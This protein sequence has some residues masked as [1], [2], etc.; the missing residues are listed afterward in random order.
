MRISLK[1][2]V[3]WVLA[4]GLAY[5]YVIASGLPK[6]QSASGYVTRFEEFGYSMSFM[7]LVGIYETA[8]GLLLLIPMT[9]FYAAVALVVE[10]AGATYSHLATGVGS[11]Y[12][13]LRAM[14]FLLILAWLRQPAYLKKALT[15]RT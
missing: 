1:S 4:V 6:L 11:P 9:S 13:A 7:F 15:K 10:M 8:A 2:A 5:V 3:A 12:H 14:A